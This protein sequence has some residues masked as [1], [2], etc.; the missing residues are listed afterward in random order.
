MRSSTV[1]TSSSRDLR[2]HRAIHPLGR[3]DQRLSD[4]IH[5]SGDGNPHRRSDDRDRARVEDPRIDKYP[6]RARRR[7]LSSRPIRAPRAPCRSS[8]RPLASTSSQPRP[9]SRS[10]RNSRR[11]S[12]DR[13]E[14][15]RAV[16]GRQGSGVLVLQDARRRDDPRPRDEADGRG[17][18][19]RRDLRG[20]A[21]KGLRRSGRAPPGSGGRILASI[22]EEDRQE[23][24]PVLRRYRAL[25][26]EL[27][28]TPLTHAALKRLLASRAPRS[29]RS[30]TARPTSRR[31]PRTFHRPRHQRRESAG[32][33]SPTTIR[34]AERRSR[35]ASLA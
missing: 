2:A 12:T 20:R 25:G 26:F 35:P 3:L 27:V 5:R 19:H 28:A 31:D 7:A 8:R 24:L 23:A 14:A 34:C 30:R 4:P 21:P 10:A 17:A 9:G 13:P 32:A 1:T 6:V 18:R 29:T 33:R 22:S 16:H 15:T 11:W